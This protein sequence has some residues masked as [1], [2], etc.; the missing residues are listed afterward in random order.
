MQVFLY[1]LITGG[2]LSG[3]P[4]PDSLLREG[5]A[6]LLALAEDFAALDGVKVVALRDARLDKEL[7]L[8]E[9]REVGEP[10]GTDGSPTRASETRVGEPPAPPVAGCE[11]FSVRDPAEELARFERLA[12]ESDWTVDIAPEFDGLLLDR[13]R[14]VE[15]GG[16]R[17]LG[18]SSSLIALA[19][20]KQRT[21]EH[22]A[23]A[24]VPVPAG[25]VLSAGEPLPKDFAYPAILKPLDGAGSQDV[26]LIFGAGKPRARLAWRILVAWQR[27]ARVVFGAAPCGRPMRLERYHSGVPASVAVLCGPRETIILP[28]GRQHLS[29]D[30]R[31]TYRGGWL[32]MA[33][34]LTRRAK[35]LA[36]AAVAALDA[37]LG[38]LGF[39]LVLGS[40]ADG[41]V[42][43]VIESNP[44]L[45]TSYV[46]LR[47]MCAT[48]LAAAMLDL[49][50]SRPPDVSFRREGLH[51]SADGVI[52][53]WVN[54]H[55]LPEDRLNMDILALDIG[56][57]NL[58]AADGRGYVA[59]RYF[60][61][62]QEPDGLADALRGV[63][64]A[65]PAAEHVAVT[66]TG[67]LADCYRTK[68]EGVTRILEALADATEGRTVSVYLTDGSFATPDVARREP[69]RA[70]ASNWRA[71]AEFAGR[72]APM[73]PALLVDIGSTTTDLVPLVEGRPA[74]KGLTDPE[75][76]M[77][78]E[79]VY[80]GAQRSPICAVARM[81][82]WRGEDCPTAQELFATTWDAY[83]LLDKLPEE[84]K[85]THT[86]DG[87]PATKEFARERL[88]R[89]I[90]A[91]RGM[92]DKDDARAAAEAVEAAQLDLLAAAARRVIDR[93]PGEPETVIVSGRGEFLILKLLARLRLAPRVVSL[94]L[95]FGS[96]VGRCATAHALAA[97][98][99]EEE[100]ENA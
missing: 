75:R 91:D 62:W 88:A 93:L 44:R 39:D 10:G 60:P 50:E 12:A 56:G 26:R 69:L 54:H 48:N 29:T 11:F 57:A 89:S 80:T 85:A 68:G 86:A 13:A 61:L 2:G 46:G 82:P 49:A 52:S 41:G 32:P 78:G 9:S 84:P 76:L 15:R 65:A 37:P 96:R 25:R 34:D 6:M 55:W 71:L 28:P 74:P 4:L 35:R 3:Q 20:D 8:I 7:Q 83:L 72:Y 58:K 87:R 36:Q 22:L 66:M 19:S 30:A 94:G 21:A 70:A 90:C 64:A 45:T 100:G 43:V 97:L 51:F 31:F 16:G 38:Y 92:F 99:R 73:G 33:N 79:L 81:L 18:P 95:E 67:E 14:R 23:A 59:T 53:R 24:G 17:L 1:E 63:L 77:A 40:A 5:R 27:I 98:A 47:A 42:D